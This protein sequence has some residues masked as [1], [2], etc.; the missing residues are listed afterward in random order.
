MSIYK[1]VSP[2]IL[3]KIKDYIDK[4]E[5]VSVSEEFL[6]KSESYRQVLAVKKTLKKIETGFLY[7]DRNENIVEDKNL[8]RELSRLSYYLNVFFND[9]SEISIK[10]ALKSAE[11]REREIEDLKDVS[12]SLRVLQ[13][14]GVKE[15]GVVKDITDKIQDIIERYNSKT[16]E[17]NLKAD[18][19]KNEG[20][21][22]SEEILAKLYP[23]YEE[24]LLLNYE[25]IKLLSKSREEYDAIKSFASKKKAANLFNRKKALAFTKIVYT[26]EYYKRLLSKHE[27]IIGMTKQQYLSY[28][29]ESENSYIEK[30]IQLI[31]SVKL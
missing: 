1:S 25:K 15:A 21:R 8:Q 23:I 14:Q 3:E 12:E 5:S 26:M 30:R 31:K 10:K 24:G 4:G 17:I 28:I 13:E 20:K 2:N 29:K 19:Y 16:D 7:I 27:N 9:D 11:V 22:F 18:E 6:W